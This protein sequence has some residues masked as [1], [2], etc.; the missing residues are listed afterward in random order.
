[1]E[2]DKRSRSG[3]SPVNSE[4]YL[5]RGFGIRKGQRT[6][7]RLA[8]GAAPHARRHQGV[9]RARKAQLLWPAFPAR[10]VLHSHCFGGFR[11]R[12]NPH[13]SGTS[14]LPQTVHGTYCRRKKPTPFV[15]KRNCEF[16]TAVGLNNPPSQFIHGAV[17]SG[18]N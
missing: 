4:R 12:S 15:M 1:M 18:L 8:R 13:T 3:M 7:S 16:V 2:K 14:L 5:P 11:P 10:T 17:M 9:L 6:L